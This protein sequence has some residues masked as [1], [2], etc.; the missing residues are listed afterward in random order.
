MKKLLDVLLPAVAVTAALAVAYLELRPWLLAPDTVPVILSAEGGGRQVHP[1][2]RVLLD[3]RFYLERNQSLLPALTAP[4]AAGRVH[5]FWADTCE[6]TQGAFRKFTQWLDFQPAHYRNALRLPGQPQQWKHDSSTRRH[7]ISGRLSAP[8][9]GLTYY[10]AHAYCAAAAGR[11][12]TAAEWR[13]MASGTGDGGGE[14]RLYPWGGGFDDAPWPYLDPLLNA[15]QPC[16][17][18]PAAATPDGV[19]DLGGGVSEWSSGS[20]GIPAVH[21]GNGGERPY[22][23]NALSLAWTP[24]HPGRRSPFI[25][26]RCVYDAPPPM[27]GWRVAPAVAQVQPGLAPPPVPA[28]AQVPRLLAHLPPEDY[29][30]LPALVRAEEEDDGAAELRVM[31]REVTR[32]EYARFLRDPLARIG[33]YA[34]PGEPRAQDYTPRDWPAQLRHPHRPVTGVD[35]GSAPADARWAGGRLPRAG[36]WLQTAA[37]HPPTTRPWGDAFALNAVTLETGRTAPEAAGATPAD[38]TRDGVLD[39]A[40]NVSE[41]TATLHIG[42]RGFAMVVKGGNFILPGAPTTTAT[43]ANA[44]P[45]NHRSPAVGFRVVFD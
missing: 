28:A 20:G 39:M 33:I 4:P 36:E 8:A 16:G 19:H 31:R 5:G 45:P 2:D 15:A 21:G 32:A 24:A 34:D 42:A 22:A 1:L 40:G 26:F 35:W 13:A 18:H 7:R 11:L 27:P 29:A 23:L 12:P 25:G 43:F 10:D 9:S 14:G 37:G 6:V 41:W 3:H 38:R 17:L 30:L 44:M